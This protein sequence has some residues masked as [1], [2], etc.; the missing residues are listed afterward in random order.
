MQF[1]ITRGRAIRFSSQSRITMHKAAQ[2]CGSTRARSYPSRVVVIT[3]SLLPVAFSY[4]TLTP[5]PEKA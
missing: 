5:S 2:Q 1:Y 4:G 3:H